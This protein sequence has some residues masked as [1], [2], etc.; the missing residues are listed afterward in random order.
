MYILGI[1]SYIK[2]KSTGEKRKERNTSF[3]TY[4]DNMRSDACYILGKHRRQTPN[5]QER[6][7]QN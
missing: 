3:G 5:E 1:Y 6:R 4:A 7:R 2:E